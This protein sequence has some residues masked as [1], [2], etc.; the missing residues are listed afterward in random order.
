V[1]DQA[2]A[3]SRSQHHARVLEKTLFVA[4][5][6]TAKG[7]N[8]AMTKERLLVLA[9]IL[10]AATGLALMIDPAVVARLLVGGD[11][12]GAGTAL[13]R[14]AGFGLLSLGLACWP[15]S[16]VLRGPAPAFRAMLTYNVLVAIYLLCLGISGEGDGKLLWPAVAIH[17]LLTLLLVRAWVKERHAEHGSAR[18]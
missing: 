15:G 1:F 12:T 10:E 3:Q 4:A 7:A 14:V 6:P 5:Y 16:D 18:Q 2:Q 8:P 11:L 13:G 17:A 9:A